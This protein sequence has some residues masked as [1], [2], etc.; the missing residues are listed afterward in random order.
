MSKEKKTFKE[1]K[2]SVAPPSI[3]K[4]IPVLLILFIVLAFFVGT[5]WQKV[6]TLS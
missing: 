4:L 1:I 3:N 2:K 6:Q 5:L